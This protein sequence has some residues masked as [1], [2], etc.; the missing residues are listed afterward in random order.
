MLTL[1]DYTRTLRPYMPLSVVP[2]EAFER[3]LAL[4]SHFP[5]TLANNVFGLEVHLLE[6]QPFIDVFLYFPEG[7]LPLIPAGASD[8]LWQEHPTWQSFY[9]FFS[10]WRE[11]TSLLYQKTDQAWL[12][13]DLNQPLP[14]IP[15]PGLFYCSIA[16]DIDP[17]PTTRLLTT[18]FRD[19]DEVALV[20]DNLAHCLRH[21]P[22]GARLNQVGFGLLRSS[23]IVRLQI[24]KFSPAGI[25]SYLKTI[26]WT[27]PLEPL[28]PMLDQLSSADLLTLMIDLSTKV[29]PK[30]G[31]EFV[32]NGHD[33]RW[34]TLLD[35][36]VDQG[37]CQPAKRDFLIPYPGIKMCRLDDEVSLTRQRLSHIKIGYH[38]EHPSAPFEAKAYLA[39]YPQWLSISDVGTGI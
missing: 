27:Y 26:G 23:G 18:L 1:A 35:A 31:L 10:V 20:A 37:L 32:L 6:D 25:A 9:R 38:P 4:T 36:L 22:A 12:A 7:P 15:T 14:D 11:P 3:V 8:H 5:A 13:F 30:I 21:I 33:S 28:Q 29:H 34:Q 39:Y 24:V 16:K 2:H 17:L 19:P